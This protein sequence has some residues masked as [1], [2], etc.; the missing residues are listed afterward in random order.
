[1]YVGTKSLIRRTA[2]DRRTKQEYLYVERL[3]LNVE[4]NF[5]YVERNIVSQRF[6]YQLEG[7]QNVKDTFLEPTRGFFLEDARK[8]LTAAIISLLVPH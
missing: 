6:H 1:M 8:K 5:L 7:N 3:F 4:R 2:L